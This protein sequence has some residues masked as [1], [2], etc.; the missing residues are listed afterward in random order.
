M[1]VDIIFE[2]HAMTS[3]DE[4][5]RATGWQPGQLSAYG[6]RCARELGERRRGDGLGAIFCSDL[7]RAVATVELAFRGFRIPVHRDT[8]LR[9]CDFGDLDGAPLTEVLSRQA[10]H[11]DQ[12]FPNGQSFRQVVDQ[13][14]GF[15]R[16]LAS[17]WDGH[18]V[19]VVAHPSTRWALEHLINGRPLT[20][21]VARPEHHPEGW[22]YA[23]PSGWAGQ[24]SDDG[25]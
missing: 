20:D 15:L 2:T 7:D 8:R 22:A 19:L 12:P 23:L 14:Y 18:R 13:A 4:A 21:P 17:A 10:V 16:D 1:G 25:G 9:E 3:D 6:R 5:G 11:L 24:R